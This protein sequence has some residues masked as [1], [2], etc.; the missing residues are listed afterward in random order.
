MFKKFQNII[1]D[2]LTICIYSSPFEVGRNSSCK[3]SIYKFIY[4]IYVYIYF[5]IAAQY[6]LL[7]GVWDFRIPLYATFTYVSHY[8]V[9]CYQDNY[10]PR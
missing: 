4:G 7:G 6:S 1:L 9:H 10:R 3:K 2:T 5:T 8:V